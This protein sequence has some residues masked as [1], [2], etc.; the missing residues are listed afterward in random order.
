MP[1]W[2]GYNEEE[3]MKQ[4]IIALSKVCFDSRALENL[5][6][7][8]HSAQLDEVSRAFVGQTKL[9]AQSTC[10][11]SV[12]LRLRGVVSSRDCSSRGRSESRENAL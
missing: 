11:R 2:V 10:W 7:L 12:Q 9:P 4:Q 6:L 1:P 8:M 5:L 3:S